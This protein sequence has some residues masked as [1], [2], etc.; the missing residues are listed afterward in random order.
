MNL[1]IYDLVAKQDS[2]NTVVNANYNRYTSNSASV[3]DPVRCIQLGLDT[4]LVQYTSGASAST[5]TY[6]IVAA[7]T[8]KTIYN[9]T[10]K[11][12]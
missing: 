3:R 2:T 4:Q 6:P 1:V 12:T 9:I 7:S 11:P 5:G 10:L 8:A